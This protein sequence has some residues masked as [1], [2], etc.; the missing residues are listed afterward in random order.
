MRQTH[1]YVTLISLEGINIMQTLA[2]HL[3]Q[4]APDL[5]AVLGQNRHLGIQIS[6]WDEQLLN[7]RTLPVLFVQRG[8]VWHL[9]QPEIQQHEELLHGLRSVPA[10][11]HVLDTGGIHTCSNTRAIVRFRRVFRLCVQK[12]S[13]HLH[14][15]AVF[16]A[17]TGHIR[18]RSAHYFQKTQTV[19]ICDA[20]E[21]I[22]QIRDVESEH[23]WKFHRFVWKQP[24]WFHGKLPEL[25]FFG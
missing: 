8:T 25:P 12:N 7:F 1:P 6:R 5:L 23:G 2:S 17:P 10:Q 19:Q 14:G 20:F 9:F 11:W 24:A 13:A 22:A 21:G 4:T 3:S 15:M 18:H 16:E